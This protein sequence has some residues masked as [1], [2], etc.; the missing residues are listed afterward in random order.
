MG[1][2]VIV[3]LLPQSRTEALWLATRVAYQGLKAE[4]SASKPAEGL[5]ISPP[6]FPPCYLDT[7]FTGTSTSGLTNCKNEPNDPS[8]K[9]VQF[10]GGSQT[11]HSNESQFLT[12]QNCPV[13]YNFVVILWFMTI[14]SCQWNLPTRIH[15]ILD[16]LS[17]NTPRAQQCIIFPY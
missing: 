4:I 6:P 11:S 7:W 9:L 16:L 12:Q 17:R 5:W 14:P 15:A 3:I 1:Q 10:T 13:N 8:P 2:G